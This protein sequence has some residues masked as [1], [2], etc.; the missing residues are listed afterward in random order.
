MRWLLRGIVSLAVYELFA[1][2][3][4]AYDRKQDR[5]H[6]ARLY[7]LRLISRKEREVE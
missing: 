1:L 7:R 4:K 5:K 6:G 2:V 3:N